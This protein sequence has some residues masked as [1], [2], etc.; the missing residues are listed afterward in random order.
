MPS[1]WALSVPLPSRRSWSPALIT[2]R[3]GLELGFRLLQ[4]SSPRQIIKFDVRR[5]MAGSSMQIWNRLFIS[6]TN[7]D[8]A[9]FRTV[10]KTFLFKE[11]LKY[12]QYSVFFNPLTILGCKCISIPILFYYLFQKDFCLTLFILLVL[13]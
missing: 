12:L 9:E 2:S 8:S 11:Y 1:P 3:E 5:W 10:S 13:C 6:T 7:T 4:I